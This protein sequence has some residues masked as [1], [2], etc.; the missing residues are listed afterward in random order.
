MRFRKLPTR[1]QEFN[2]TSAFDVIFFDAFAPRHQPEMWALEVFKR[3]HDAL[4]PGGLLV[5]YCAKGEV[6]RTMQSAGFSVERLPGPPGK[7]EMLRARKS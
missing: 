5:T 7:R 6:R 4:R 2:E 1:V 3:M